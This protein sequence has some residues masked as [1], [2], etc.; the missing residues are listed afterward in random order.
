MFS[1]EK[2]FEKQPSSHSQTQFKPIKAMLQ[3]ALI[4]WFV[5]TL[6]PI[7]ICEVCNRI[8]PLWKG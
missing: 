2:Y 4:A 6:D 3:C 7:L 8:I 1:S 5:S